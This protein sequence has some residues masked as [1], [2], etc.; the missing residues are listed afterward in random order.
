MVRIPPYL[1][2]HHELIPLPS[3]FMKM[4]QLQADLSYKFAIL[5]GKCPYPLT[6]IKQLSFAYQ[7]KG[8]SYMTLA[9]VVGAENI[10]DVA[11]G[12]YFVTNNPELYPKLKLNFIQK[13]L[14]NEVAGVQL[15]YWQRI[16]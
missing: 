8:K 12:G 4:G 2:C 9:A 13:D 11:I 6:Y 16:R 3:K 5:Q 1:L 10:E 14:S 15:K 7:V